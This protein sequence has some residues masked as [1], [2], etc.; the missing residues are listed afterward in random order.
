MTRLRSGERERKEQ[1][2]QESLM[3][4]R[5]PSSEDGDEESTHVVKVNRDKP[6]TGKESGAH[7]K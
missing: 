5:G 2:L 1:E 7:T 3:G 6:A 4:P